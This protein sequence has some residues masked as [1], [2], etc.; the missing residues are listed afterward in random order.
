MQFT[1]AARFTGTADPVLVT[2]NADYMLFVAYVGT[3]VDIDYAILS[4]N[5]LQWEVGT[6]QLAV[7]GALM[8]NTVTDN[9]LSSTAKVDFDQGRHVVLV[10]EQAAGGVSDGDKGDITV[11]GGGAAW[12]LDLNLATIDAPTT[13]VN[14]A[15]QQSQQFRIE[16]RT[17]DPGAPLDGE[18]W[19]RTDLS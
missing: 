8:R 12:S 2:S 6:G 10:Q 11:S 7:G 17:S 5:G 19:L 14:F 18:I 1:T 3:G 13:A 9:H 15:Q 4:E 16:N